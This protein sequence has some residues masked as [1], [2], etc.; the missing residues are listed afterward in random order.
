[1]IPMT[2]PTSDRNEIFARLQIAYA[3]LG[4][5]LPTGIESAPLANLQAT[6]DLA[7]VTKGKRERA[8]ALAELRRTLSH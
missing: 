2:T 7:E 3:D 4:W 1:M 5:A 8:A 6:L